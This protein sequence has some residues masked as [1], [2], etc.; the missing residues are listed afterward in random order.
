MSVEAWL[1]LL[2]AELVMMVGAFGSLLPF[3]PSTP[4]VFL[5]ALGH[6]LY[7]GDES[8]SMMV[9]VMLGCATLLSLVVDHAAGLIGARKLGATWRGVL[10]AVIGGGI[11]IFIGPWGILI[12]PFAGALALELSGGRGLG[13]A[14]KAGA[15]A[16]LGV[17]AGTLGKFACALGM[18]GLFAGNL[19]IRSW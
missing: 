14:S 6:K 7:F 2:L 11:G 12:G 8:V 10:G 13:E 19:I 18:A 5:A 16:L 17:M 3:I 15:G 9:M 1:G 4:L